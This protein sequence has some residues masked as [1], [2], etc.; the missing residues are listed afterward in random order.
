MLNQ[1][2]K[3]ITTKNMISFN[4]F[5]FLS[6]LSCRPSAQVLPLWSS[7]A[8]SSKNKRFLLNV[9]LCHSQFFKNFDRGHSLRIIVMILGGHDWIHLCKRG[10]DK[11]HTNW[12]CPP[13]LFIFWFYT[14]EM[15]APV[16]SL[17]NL[18]CRI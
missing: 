1:W 6:S 15:S 14:S 5:T 16:T 7:R 9:S 3:A 4:V 11:R 10:R 18:S 8:G 2:R 17:I 12:G 13:F